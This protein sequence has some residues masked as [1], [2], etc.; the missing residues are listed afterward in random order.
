MDAFSSNE[1][2]EYKT[3]PQLNF[4]GGHTA[5]LNSCVYCAEIYRRY[6]LKEGKLPHKEP[7]EEVLEDNEPKE[8]EYTSEASKF[9]S[10]KMQDD[11]CDKLMCI[12]A[13][14]CMCDWVGLYNVCRN[15]IYW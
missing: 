13:G 6:R 5:G 7:E 14:W 12:R 4:Q 10:K 11:E 1:L 9:V 2:E 8:E 15:W 3:C